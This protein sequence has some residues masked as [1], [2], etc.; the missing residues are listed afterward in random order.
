VRLAIGTF[1]SRT[2]LAKINTAIN[3][4]TEVTVVHSVCY[5]LNVDMFIILY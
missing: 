5:M 1:D 2:C 3:L 4:P